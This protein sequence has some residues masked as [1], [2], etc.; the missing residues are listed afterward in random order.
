VTVT[1]LHTHFVQLCLSTA[2]IGSFA[3]WR[4]APEKLVRILNLVEG[5]IDI[6][7]PNPR[8]QLSLPLS[9]DRL[10]NVLI[11]IS[12]SIFSVVF[13]NL[14]ILLVVAAVL[15][16]IISF[17]ST[18]IVMYVTFIDKR[19]HIEHSVQPSTLAPAARTTAIASSSACWTLMNLHHTDV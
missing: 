17:S 13:F 19:S 4:M 7:I 1:D 11:S 10:G 9:E 14:I 12:K 18:S 15:T 3:T 5:G 6:S 16:V 8:R 2:R